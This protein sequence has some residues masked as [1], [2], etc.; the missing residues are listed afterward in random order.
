PA[1]ADRFEVIAFDWP[2]MGQSDAWT[3]GTTPGHQAE[4]L[5]KLLDWWGIE[6]AHIAGADMGGQ[7]ALVFAARYPTRIG[8]LIVMNSLTHGD[9]ETSWEIRVLRKF[10]WNRLI[11]RRFPALV[12]RPAERTFLPAGTRLAPE[13]RSDLWESFRR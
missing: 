8:R 10:G 5:C 6:R 9:A 1:L 2:G 11:L 12:F 13:L 4:R 3:G 7:P